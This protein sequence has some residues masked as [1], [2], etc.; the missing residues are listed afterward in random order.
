MRQVII[1]LCLVCK[2]GSLNCYD[3]DREP[4]KIY[5]STC[6]EKRCP[7]PTQ[8]FSSGFCDAHFPGRLEELKKKRGLL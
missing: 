1:T 2:I 4:K 5:C 3:S 7:T 8:G 6:T